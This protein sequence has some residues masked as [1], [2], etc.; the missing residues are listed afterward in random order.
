MRLMKRPPFQGP[1]TDFILVWRTS[2]L[3]FLVELKV[4]PRK[5]RWSERVKKSCGISACVN[6]VFHFPRGKNLHFFEA[7]VQCI[8]QLEESSNRVI[9]L[10]ISRNSQKFV[11]TG[12][13]SSQYAYRVYLVS[14]LGSTWCLAGGFLARGVAG[15]GGRAGSPG[16]AGGGG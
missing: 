16:M 2:P 11:T 6:V 15:A 9:T 3:T 13:R 12:F 4:T 8:R 1:I 7:A 10:A 5:S 14:R